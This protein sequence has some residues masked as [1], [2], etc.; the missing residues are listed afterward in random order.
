MH[1]Y[2]LDVIS[3]FIQPSESVSKA[4][5]YASLLRYFRGNR[6][7]AAGSIGGAVRGRYIVLSPNN[8]TYFCP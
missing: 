3:L 8:T 6:F 4:A 2:P 5:L 7:A 1:P